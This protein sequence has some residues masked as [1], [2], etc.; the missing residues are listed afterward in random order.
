M[1]NSENI[2]QKVKL[3][4]ET[5][6]QWGKEVTRRFGDRIRQCKLKMKRLRHLRDHHS[7][8][9]YKKVK[10]ELFLILEQREIF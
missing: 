7:V 2:H 10:D 5:L 9:M 1:N 3:C 4:G 8:D 6:N